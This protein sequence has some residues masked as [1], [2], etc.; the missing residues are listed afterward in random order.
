MRLISK[1]AIGQRGRFYRKSGGRAST[2]SKRRGRPPRRELLGRRRERGG[3]STFDLLYVD[4]LTGGADRTVEVA[5]GAMDRRILGLLR[6]EERAKVRVQR[7]D[8]SAAIDGEFEEFA[9]C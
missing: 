4:G 1:G 6:S 9:S 7:D 8:N 5:E 2:E 3:G